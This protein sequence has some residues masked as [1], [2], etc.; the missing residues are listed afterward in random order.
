MC[1]IVKQLIYNLNKFQLF[2]F[3]LERNARDLGVDE[4]LT[5]RATYRIESNSCCGFGLSSPM[6]PVT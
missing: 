4:K 5:E 6:Q 1:I 3:Y 2:M